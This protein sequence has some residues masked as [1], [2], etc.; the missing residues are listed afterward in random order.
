MLRYLI[1]KRCM[2]LV[3]STALLLVVAVAFVEIFQGWFQTY[4]SSLF[5]RIEQDSSVDVMNTRIDTILGNSLYFKNGY[6]NLT[7]TEIK[8]NDVSCLIDESYGKGMQTINISGCVE[9]LDNLL[10]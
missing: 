4:S 1:N 7:I 9:T 5:P 10:I 6:N 2:S 3:V 8:L